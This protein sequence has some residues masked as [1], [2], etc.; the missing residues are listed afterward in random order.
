MTEKIKQT[1]LQ[2]EA[3][4]VTHTGYTSH[5]AQGWVN[6]AWAPP[7]PILIHKVLEKPPVTSVLGAMPSKPIELSFGRGV[8]AL[9]FN[10]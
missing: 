9:G 7:A 3:Q 5:K 4:L 8:E 10:H 1:R 6:A 2:L